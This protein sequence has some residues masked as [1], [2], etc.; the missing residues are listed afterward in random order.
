MRIVEFSDSFYP[1]MDGVGNVVFQYAMNL[2]RKG[3]ECYVV[4][5]Q[6]DTG[7]RGG[8]PFE[9]IDYVGVPL[10]TMKSYNAGAPQLDPHCSRRLGMVKADI[11]HVHTPFL[12]GQAGLSYAKRNGL[13]VVGTFH[14]KYYDDFLQ[15]TGVELLAEVGTRAV[16]DFY[17]RCDEVWAVSASSAET[18]RSYGYQG[19]VRV[20]TNGTDI[21]PLQPGAAEAAAERWGLGEGRVLLFVGQMNWKKN[22]RCVL[23]AAAK[24][25]GGVRLVLAGQGPHEQEI[26]ALGDSLGLGDRLIMTGHLTD[27]DALNG[28]YARADL[29][30]FP[31]LYDTSGLVTREAAAVGTPSVAVR[32]SSAAEGLTDGENGYLCADDPEDLARVIAGALADPAALKRVGAQA[33]ATIPIPWD[34]LLDQVAARY[35]ALISEK[36]GD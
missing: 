35:A 33:K 19:Q 20:M 1:I 31:S 27:R 26:R 15:I 22:L 18:L 29:F 6:T 5:P 2:G 3:H 23:E 13:P 11:V 21:V 9:M 24:L 36:R 8:W 4:A 32:G 7:W 17:N 12:A 10:P 34:R 30:L 14:S 16:V 25:E 28:L